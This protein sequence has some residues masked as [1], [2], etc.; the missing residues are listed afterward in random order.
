VVERAVG[1]ELLLHEGLAAEHGAVGEMA[2]TATQERGQRKFAASSD[3]LLE[4]FGRDGGGVV[5]RGGGGAEEC[6]AVAGL[7]SGPVGLVAKRE[8]SAL[9][10]GVARD[11]FAI[12]AEA[13]VFRVVHEAGADGVEVDVRGD[14]FDGASGGLDQEGFEALRPEGA[15][16]AVAFVEPDREALFDQLHELRDVAHEG[17]LTLAPRIAFGAA[18]AE[19]GFDDVETG[20]LKLGGRRVKRSIAP[21]KFGVGERRALRHHQQHVE[22]VR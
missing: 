15:V 20:R 4:R 16:A 18:G 11:G 3:D 6:E 13:V 1:C 9:G 5:A 8:E 2:D 21:Q 7:R 12:A 22:M 17:E 14:S 19:L 10:V